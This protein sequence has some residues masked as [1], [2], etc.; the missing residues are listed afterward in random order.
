MNN[1]GLLLSITLLLV[2]AAAVS[3]EGEKHTQNDATPA[4][5]S[6]EG[7]AHIVI[8]DGWVT[9]GPNVIKAKRGDTVRLTF[10]SNAEDELHLHGYDIAIPLLPN[11]IGVLEFEA[12]YPGRFGYE[13]HQAHRE[14]GAVEIYP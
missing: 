7:Q 6:E 8:T 3:H 14:I 4:V 1:L 5:V 9:E 2:P 10:M 11:Q 12:K 13:L